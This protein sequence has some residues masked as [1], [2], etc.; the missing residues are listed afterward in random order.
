MSG[1]LAPT[2]SALLI[3]LSASIGAGFSANVNLIANYYYGVI[4]AKRQNRVKIMDEK[5]SLY[6]YIIYH[7]DK[8]GFKA[9]VIKTHVGV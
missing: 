8:M 7:I 9:D 3:G 5:L 6:S 2:D 1:L 4:T